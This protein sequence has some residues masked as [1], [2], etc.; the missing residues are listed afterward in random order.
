MLSGPRLGNDPPLAHPQGEQGLAQRVVDLVRPR[1]IEVLALE[2]DLCPAALL[3][4]P[5]GEIQRRRPA[6]IVLVQLTEFRLESRIGRGLG[7]LGRQF[8]QGARQ[9]FGNIASA[10]LA[11]AAGRIGNARG[12]GHGSG[13]I[14]GRKT[15]IV[16]FRTAAVKGQAKGKSESS[17]HTPCACYL[18][19]SQRHDR[20]IAPNRCL[21]W[22]REIHSRGPNLP[23]PRF[24]D[25]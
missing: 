18:A 21:P 4:Q 24:G 2:I 17:R 8:V 22:M 9:G 3:R 20:Q 19:V 6:D 12:G 13:L 16:K 14:G 15:S 10:E 11:E 23:S 7:V 5:A 1:M 25:M